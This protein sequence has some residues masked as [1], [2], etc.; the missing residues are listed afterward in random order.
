MNPSDISA[1]IGLA[2]LAK[3]DDMQKYRKEI[4]NMYQNAFKGYDWIKTPVE[5]NPGDKHSY[6]TYAIRVPK[7][8]EL[9]HYLFDNGIYSTLRYHPLHLNKLYEQLNTKLF[10]AEQLNEDAL[11]IPLHPNLKM[12][13]VE[14]IIEKVKS[15]YL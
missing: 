8:D 13:E 3:L 15:F 12:S 4:W 11:S 7:R 14:Y 5:A 9:A 6:F 10:N 2:Q 1:G